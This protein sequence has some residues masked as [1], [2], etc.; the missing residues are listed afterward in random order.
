MADQLI[1][2]TAADNGIRAV[3]VITTQLTQEARERHGLSY[4]ATAALGRSMAGA[5]LLRSEERRVGKECSS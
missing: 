1:R 2:A 5:L 3:G 4:V